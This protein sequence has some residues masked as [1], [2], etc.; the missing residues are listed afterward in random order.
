MKKTKKMPDG[1]KVKKKTLAPAP[2]KQYSDT[3]IYGNNT[4]PVFQ[5]ADQVHNIDVS[6]HSK[7]WVDSVLNANADKNFVQRY[8]HPY[9][10]PVIDNKTGQ[11][12]SYDPAR[13]NYSSLLMA[14]EGNR[15]YP[16]IVQGPA[17]QLKNLGNNDTAYDFA[18]TNNEFI[19]FKNSQDARWFSSN[20]YKLGTQYPKTD[21]TMK[22]KMPMGGTIPPEGPK[23]KVN[24][25]PSQ[26]ELSRVGRIAELA[27]QWK[28]PTQNIY[29]QVKYGPKDISGKALRDYTSYWTF[30]PQGNIINSTRDTY[31]NTVRGYSG[32]AMYTQKYTQPA[33]DNGIASSA[34]QITPMSV[35]KYGGST[36]SYENGG[37]L[38]RAQDY[39]SKARPYPSVPSGDFAGGE[40]SYPIPTKA[41]AVD[42]LRLAALHGRDDVKAK[43]YAKYPDLKKAEYGLKLMQDYHRMPDGSMMAN[44]QMK[45]GGSIDMETISKYMGGIPVAKNGIHINPANKGKFTASASKAGMGVQEFASHVLANKGKYSPTQVKRAN[46]A[47][48]AN[49]WHKAEF[50][51]DIPGYAQPYEDPSLMTARRKIT[52]YFQNDPQQGMVPNN[53]S[54]NGPD[55]YQNEYMID[56]N[57]NQVSQSDYQPLGDST[58]QPIQPGPS[59]HIGQGMPNIHLNA[60]VA[61]NALAGFVT[62][63]LKKSQEIDEFSRLKRRNLT[64]QTYNPNA[65]GTGSQAIMKNGGSINKYQLTPE[66][67][68][69]LKKQGYNI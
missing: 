60:G 3:T 41:D 61:I 43:V 30:D 52:D 63:G 54:V 26:E 68:Q 24:M 49:K 15:S 51:T 42:A 56:P 10:F 67:A 47:R 23:K 50:G 57:N 55:P 13:W 19:N 44:D 17:G 25:N 53:A 5:K 27:K 69:F 11:N 20:A 18:D 48:N 58:A 45:Y 34:A 62:K 38:S 14:D 8:Q 12:A 36:S 46:F 37:G 2:Y 64:G 65:Y 16:T 1:G 28:V 35:Q 33:V 32:S 6:V 9:D 66:Q 21:T 59:T 7:Q 40:R 4:H 39:G 29:S 22:K 31:D